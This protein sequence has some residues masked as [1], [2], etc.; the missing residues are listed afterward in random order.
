[1]F[2]GWVMPS[3]HWLTTFHCV[4]SPIVSQP[5]LKYKLFIHPNRFFLRQTH[6]NSWLLKNLNSKNNHMESNCMIP[7]MPTHPQLH[8][9]IWKMYA[10][11][12]TVSYICAVISIHHLHDFWQ[13]RIPTWQVRRFFCLKQATRKWWTRSQTPTAPE[14]A[15]S[16]QALPP[17][18]A[19]QYTLIQHSNITAK[20]HDVRFFVFLWKALCI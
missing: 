15:P 10:T 5:N 8:R 2:P 16:V 14:S 20:C 12:E 13:A 11:V 6:V 19:V 3:Q 18:S 9:K 4:I 1:M 7:E 17:S